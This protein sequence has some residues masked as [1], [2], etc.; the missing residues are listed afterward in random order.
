[1]PGKKVLER[2]SGMHPSE[3]ELPEQCTGMF[4]HKNTPDSH[5][6]TFHFALVVTLKLNSLT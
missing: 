3:K 1:M 6:Q 4:H 5:L 2:R